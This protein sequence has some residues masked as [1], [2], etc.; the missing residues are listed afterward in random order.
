MF[1]EYRLTYGVEVEQPQ[2]LWAPGSVFKAV[3]GDTTSPVLYGY[4]QDVLGIYYRASHVFQV[5]GAGGGGGRGG[6]G[7]RGGNP[8][9]VGGGNAQP[10][11]VQPQLTSLWGNAPA[12]GA[13]AGRGR[14]GRGG[15]GGF[16]RGGR[17][18]GGA[19]GPDPM[20]PRVLLSFPTDANDLLLSGG[21]VGGEALAGRAVAVD[22][23][24]GDGHVVLF[25]N[26]P[27]WRW[28]THGNFFMVF[29]AMLNWNDLDAG[30]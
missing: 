14:G 10:N 20:A 15:R 11:A 27:M 2:G 7:G 16:G 13:G 28:E 26:R 29:N 12:G 22:S 24:V 8:P 18:G 23:P 21:L 25:A 4:D 17:G 1:P 5:A 9:G 6:R 3:V 30:R 19:A